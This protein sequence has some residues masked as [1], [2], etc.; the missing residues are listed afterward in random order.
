MK[1]ITLNCPAKINLSLDILGK[2]SDGYHEIDTIMQTISLEDVIRIEK[3]NEFSL[4]VKGGDI[5]LDDRNIALKAAKLM[6]DTYKIGGGLSV[7]IEK[8]IP[9]AAG[10]AGGS[11][12]AAGVIEGIN[13]LYCLNLC[14][15]DLMD[16]AAMI[17]SDVPF[18]M[19]KG[20][21]LCKGR[22]EIVTPLKSM[23]G[24]LVLI[25]KPP[26]SVSTKEVFNNLKLEKIKKRPNNDIL[27]DCI[28]DNNIDLLSKNLVNVLETVTIPMHRVIE[29]IKN[30]MNEFGALGS[31]MSGSGPTVFG[32]F[33][34]KSI[35]DC[36]NYLKG[37]FDEVY[38]ATMK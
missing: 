29:D 21:A 10:L 19:E 26:I 20:T 15:K 25:A 5:P 17:G 18:L 1:S 22:G 6:F 31:I 11:T 13:T 35:D 12:D 34:D 27:L 30:I 23:S 28:D 33:K 24:H 37:D 8:N 9:V 36:Y 38:I 32:I 4:E 16:I 2:R 7:Y 14:K 3:S